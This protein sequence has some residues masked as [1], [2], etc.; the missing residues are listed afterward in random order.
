MNITIFN[1]VVARIVHN[2]T[3]D[4]NDPDVI[5]GKLVTAKLR[6]IMEPIKNTLKRKF[7]EILYSHYE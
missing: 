3:D 6:K 1:T 4:I 2:Q 7:M 5:I